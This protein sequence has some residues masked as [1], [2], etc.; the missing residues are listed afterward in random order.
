MK[1]GILIGVV[2]TLCLGAIAPR[3]KYWQ[4][5]ILKP[6]QGWIES[7]GYGGESVLGY[8]V[9]SLLVVQQAQNKREGIQ[10]ET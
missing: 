8:N 6:N 1:K 4:D 5:V 9:R 7:Y 2:L 10:D 3:A